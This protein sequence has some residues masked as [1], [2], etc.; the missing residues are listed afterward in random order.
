M[1]DGQ[2]FDPDKLTAASW[3]YPLGTKIHVA[4]AGSTNTVE[5]TVTDRGPSK[6]LVSRGRILDLS[7]AAFERLADPDRGVIQVTIQE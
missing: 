7:R 3:F 2:P 4:A 5:V 6:A 1:A